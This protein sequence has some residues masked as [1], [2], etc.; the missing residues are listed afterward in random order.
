MSQ[1]LPPLVRPRGEGRT[2]ALPHGRVTFTATTADTGGRFELYEVVLEYDGSPLRRHVHLQMDELI[3]VMDGDLE[4]RI[5]DRSL[6]LQPGTTLFIPRGT[7]HSWANRGRM[8]AT[9]LLH[10]S[11]S[12]QREQYFERLSR[13][14]GG[15]LPPSPEQLD[16]LARRFD[17]AP[18]DD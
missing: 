1:S 10:Y 16:D 5:G 15:P 7:P 8:P 4:A 17:E 6:R 12:G 13:L 3:V 9:V 14:V 2:V 11:P 18:I